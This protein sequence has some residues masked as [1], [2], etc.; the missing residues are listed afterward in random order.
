MSTDISRTTEIPGFVGSCLVDSDTGLML[1]SYGGRGLD[2][3]A[4]AALNSEV[5][6]AKLEA[7]ANLGLD[8]GIED[9]LVTLR[10]QYQLTRLLTRNPSVFIYLV[11]DRKK[12]NLGMARLMLK[13]VEA[14]LDI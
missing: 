4:A 10:K 6:R 3:E 2:L 12:A 14:G 9:I 11:L 7:I 1:T 8:D 5:V 13:D